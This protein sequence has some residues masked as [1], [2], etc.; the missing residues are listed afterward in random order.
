MPAPIPQLQDKSWLE[1][2]YAV[3]SAQQIIRRQ[4]PLFRVPQSGKTLTS[5]LQ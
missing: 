2:A 3:Q 4:L 5:H 1:A